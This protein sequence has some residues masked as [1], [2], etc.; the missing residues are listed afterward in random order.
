MDENKTKQTVKEKT[1]RICRTVA[2][3]VI[4]FCRSCN[5]SW[6]ELA[7][8]TL[9]YVLLMTVNYFLFAMNGFAISYYK[10]WPAI[11]CIDR[12]YGLY[13]FLMIGHFLCRRSQWYC[14]SL[15]TSHFIV[16]FILL[17]I[18]FTTGTFFCESILYLVYDTTWEETK[19]FI[20]AYVSVK[21]IL[22]LIGVCIAYFVPLYFAQKLY[23]PNKKYSLGDCWLVLAILLACIPFFTKVY[24]RVNENKKISA[25]VEYCWKLHP[26][27]AVYLHIAVFN[28]HAGEFTMEMRHRTAPEFVALQENVKKDPPIGLL[29][30]GES[31]IRSHLSI[32]GYQRNTTPCLLKEKDNII[33]F[34]D[35]IAILPMTITALKYWLTDM[36]LDNRHIKW[37]IF[38]ALKKAGY[39]I[40]IITNQNKSGWAD[41]PLQMIFSTADSVTYMHEENYSDLDH[42]GNR[43]ICDE[44][45]IEPFKKL[46]ETVRNDKSGKPHLIV[47]HLFGSHEPFFSRYPQNYTREFLDDTSVSNLTNEYDTSVHYTDFV[48]GKLL[49]ELKKLK[50]PGYMIYFSDHGSKC[51]DQDLRTPASEAATAYEIPFLIWINQRYR[52]A[53]PETFKRMKN[54]RQV[55]LQA[56]RAHYGLLEMMGLRFTQDIEAKNFLSDKYEK[57]PR[58][59]LE[60]ERPYKKEVP[61]KAE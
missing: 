60:G 34:D 52:T 1:I 19:G 57:P 43:E 39:Q 20:S 53:I 40:D 10:T 27:S 13:L 8:L 61:A 9:I 15:L 28:K 33:A 45:L 23:K 5:I 31:S 37:T 48:M 59:I 42:A 30:I 50:R 26:L 54:A 7:Y 25:A 14:W 51:D 29:I 22:C 46:L 18:Y 6:G 12:L 4:Q 38:D 36:T 16:L 58:F 35:T 2:D 11:S 56:D 47:V 41:S 55:P 44:N 3:K 21:S 17:G 49:D 24:Q 32:Y